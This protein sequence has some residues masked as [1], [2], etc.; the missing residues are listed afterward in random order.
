M[1]SYKGPTCHL[2][3]HPIVAAAKDVT[4]TGT[5]RWEQV[6]EQQLLVRSSLKAPTE[7]K[8]NTSKMHTKE[9][10]ETQALS[11]LPDY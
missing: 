7:S 10:L 1:L 6:W 8:E 3:M 11:V 4:D 2:P 9:T 5:F